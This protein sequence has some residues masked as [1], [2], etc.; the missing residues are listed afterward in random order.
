MMTQ[1][2]INALIAGAGGGADDGSVPKVAVQKAVKTYDFRRPDKFSKDQL[3]TLHAIHDSIGRVAGGRLSARLRSQVTF[4]LADTSQMIFDEYVSG[5]TLPTQLVVLQA[6]QLGGPFLLDLDLGLAKGWI[7]RLLGGEGRL[8][9]ERRE[10]TSIESALILKLVDDLLPAIT[11]GW[12]QVETVTPVV[13]ETALRPDLLRVAA[14]SH[15]VA[16]L[17]YEVRYTIEQGGEGNRRS[18]VQV[19][20]MSMCLPNATL[21]P[22][23]SRLSA[24]AWYAQND[25]GT[26]GVG[27]AEIADALQ[28]VEVPLTAVLAGVELTV[29]ELAGLKPGDVIRFGERADHPVRLSVMDQAMAWAVPGK[30]GDRVALRLLTPLQHLLEA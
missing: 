9:T 7:D 20:S 25:K 26:D 23:L 4:T 16:V 12:S 14:P 17:T 6:D 5:L 24:T 28:G 19:S 18:E 22:I 2:Q 10:P 29:D 30:V 15:V 21:E 27:A 13:A 1:A 8:P 3:R 11:E